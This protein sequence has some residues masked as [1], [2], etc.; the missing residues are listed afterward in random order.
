MI[1]FKKT[2]KTYENFKTPSISCLGFTETRMWISGA[3]I[4]KST[5]YLL[6]YT[7]NNDFICPFHPQSVR[8]N[9]AN[10][11]LLIVGIEIG[12]GNQFSDFLLSLSFH[13]PRTVNTIQK[14][15]WSTV[16]PEICHWHDWLSAYIWCVWIFNQTPTT[17]LN[18][19]RVFII[20]INITES[21][22]EECNDPTSVM[23]SIS[24]FVITND[25]YQINTCTISWG[26]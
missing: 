2:L 14:R 6:H 26:K 5:I 23:S 13:F 1:I 8:C 24:R 18:D 16:S 10:L 17:W 11:K 4:L 19:P 22:R 3:Y 20:I 12:W 25:F 21:L 9:K 15:V 7:Y